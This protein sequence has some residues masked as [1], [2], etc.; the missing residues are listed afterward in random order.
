[1]RDGVGNK[2]FG[3]ILAV[4]GMRRDGFGDEA[5]RRIG[6]QQQEQKEG[7]RPPA[8]RPACGRPR[9][10]R[11][12]RPGANSVEHG[13]HLSSPPLVATTPRMKTTTAKTPM[14]AEC[15]ASRC[16]SRGP[17]WSIRRAGSDCEGETLDTRDRR[18]V[19]ARP[20]AAAALLGLK[21][22][23]FESHIEKLG[24]QRPR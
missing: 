19:A 8:G 15:Q 10:S 20:A 17:G 16:A 9:A 12:R 1:M 3:P 4:R 21:P 6:G 24:L 22:T 2:I 13:S 23:T 11:Y 5:N 14:I 18:R 7:G